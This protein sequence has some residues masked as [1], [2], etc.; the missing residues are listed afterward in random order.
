MVVHPSSTSARAARP[1]LARQGICTWTG[2]VGLGV[3]SRES[4]G[5]V[6]VIWCS[7][8]TDS[9]D[10]FRLGKQERTIRHLLPSFRR[11]IANTWNG[12]FCMRLVFKQIAGDNLPLTNF[13]AGYLD[14]LL[15]FRTPP[16]QSL[17]RAGRI[18]WIWG[19]HLARIIQRGAESKQHIFCGTKI[20]EFK[21]TQ[22]KRS[23]NRHDVESFISLV[24]KL[25][26]MQVGAVY[27]CQ[28]LGFVDFRP[29]LGILHQCSESGS[30]PSY[31]L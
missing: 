17:I 18:R 4:D 21:G 28:P 16:R 23:R 20:S 6:P 5:A 15:W 31:T 11:I 24:R 29:F 3:V 26:A 25:V 8:N 1:L 13:I 10:F 9:F 2:S 12:Q 19:G 30:Q 14:A 22:K 27:W 7:S